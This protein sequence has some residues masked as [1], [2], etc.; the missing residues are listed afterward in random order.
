MNYH[1]NYENVDKYVCAAECFSLTDKEKAKMIMH[2]V[3][4]CNKTKSLLIHGIK[5]IYVPLHIDAADG[6]KEEKWQVAKWLNG[7]LTSY[8]KKMFTRLYQ[9]CNGTVELYVETV[10]HNE[11]MD[12]ACPSTSKIAKALNDKSMEEV[13]A[14]PQDAYD[15]LAVHPE[16]KS[17]TLGK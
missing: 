8:G 15:K 4:F 7:R 2:Q 13:F 16:W 14:N 12:W 6:D 10:H 17:H 11:A 3:D 9:A 5:D 1:E